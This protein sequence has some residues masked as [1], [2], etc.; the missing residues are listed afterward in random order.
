MF[1]RCSTL[2]IQAL[3]SIKRTQIKLFHCSSFHAD[4][5]HLC[6]AVMQQD[7]EVFTGC[8]LFRD[9]ML[10]MWFVLSYC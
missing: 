6:S 7:G 9:K 1:T 5:T 10:A 3:K 8:A 4:R 2:R